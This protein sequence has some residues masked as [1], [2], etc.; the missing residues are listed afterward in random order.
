[1]LYMDS[2][3]DLDGVDGGP[4]WSDQPHDIPLSNTSQTLQTF[5]IQLSESFHFHRFLFL[6]SLLSLCLLPRLILVKLIALYSDL[7]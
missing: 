3:Y 5:S 6:L 7:L 1:M 2:S 4:P